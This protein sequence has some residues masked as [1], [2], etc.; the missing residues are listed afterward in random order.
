MVQVRVERCRRLVPQA[1]RGSQL[2]GQRGLSGGL[3]GW[4]CEF[5]CGPWSCGPVPRFNR[6][7]W[8]TWAALQPGRWGEL[9]FRL[10]ACLRS[11][12]SWTAA[13]RQ[14]A[15]PGRL[16]LFGLQYRGGESW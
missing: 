9:W 12:N 15:T 16:Q 11:C 10:D 8:F 6:K 14:A 7:S 13:R 5:R 3:R 2:T 4:V 1:R